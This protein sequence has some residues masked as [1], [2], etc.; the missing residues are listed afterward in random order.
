LADCDELGG[1]D[2]QEIERLLTPKTK[3]VVITH[4]CGNPCDMDA[5]VGMC[6]KHN[7]K[8][9]EDCSH[10]HGATYNGKMVGTFG[11]AAAW[12]MQTQKIIAAGEGG[13]LFTKDREV[14][15]RAQLLGHFNKRA[16]E[17]MDK[18]SSYYQYAT[19]GTGLKYRAHPL[20]VAIALTQL[21]YLKEWMKGKQ[22][23]AKK[24]KAIVESQ[25]GINVIE[26]RE[27]SS[28]AYYAFTFL[29]DEEKLGCSRE[30]LVNAIIAEGFED[31]D[32][33]KAMSPLHTF[34]LF[35]KP[36]SPVIEYSDSCVRGEYKNSEMIAKRIVK[37]SVPVEYEAGSRGDIFI[38]K[39]KQVWNKVFE[40]GI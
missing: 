40:N 25:P 15:D 13:V 20:G 5:I 4:M 27:K 32:I 16:M 9:V 24:I 38:D 19:T 14:Y 6:K 10:A 23:N 2:P 18:T 22:I 39:F 35:N 21:P 30:Q 12:S 11:D 17:E 26:Q 37:L 33:P 3:A 28:G 1:L 8:L 31:I 29:V 36:T 7:L 34:A